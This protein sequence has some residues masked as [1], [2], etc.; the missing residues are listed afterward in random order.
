M[1]MSLITKKKKKNNNK[2]FS[3]FSRTVFIVRK[4]S[5]IRTVISSRLK[6]EYNLQLFTVYFYM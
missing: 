1:E 6:S 3:G 4:N 5:K 2:N